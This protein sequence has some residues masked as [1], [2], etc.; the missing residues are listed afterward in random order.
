[1]NSVTVNNQDVAPVRVK[2]CG[3]TRAED[4]RALDELSVGG[5]G[6]DYLGF[7]FWPGSKRYIT[8]EA[9]RPLIASL[10]HALPVGVFV[11]HTPDEI[12]RIAAITGIRVAQ[13]HG[14]ENWDTIARV[15]LP[16]IK[17]VPQTRL[18]EWGGLR[19]E[20]DTRARADQP[21]FF[22]VDTAAAG[23]FGGTGEVFD[24]SLLSGAELPRPIFLAGGIGPHNIIDA[25]RATYPFAVDLNSKVEVSPGVKDVEQVKRCLG[26][27]ATFNDTGSEENGSGNQPNP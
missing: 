13:L 23:A 10:H 5:V 20:W 14:A 17:A 11:D 12:A 7:N 25:V 1:M 2:V 4:A 22:L 15:A 26:A 18:N 19:S 3:I 27:L 21:G 6:V 24:W 9:A 16:V 8:P